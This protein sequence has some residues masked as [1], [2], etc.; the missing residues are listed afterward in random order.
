[1]RYL[2]LK[3]E[4]NLS[5][6]LTSVL[7][8]SMKEEIYLNYRGRRGEILEQNACSPAVKLGCR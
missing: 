3:D 6:A 5:D 8:F 1:M 4:S 7:M 2:F